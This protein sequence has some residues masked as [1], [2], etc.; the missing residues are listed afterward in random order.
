[1]RRVLYLTAIAPSFDTGGGGEI[2]Q[3]HLLR[4]LAERFELHLLIAGRLRDDRVRSL[5]TSVV[6]APVP[7]VSDPPGR[8][9]RRLRDLEWAL[10]ARQPDEVA[11]QRGVRKALAQHLRDRPDV[12]AVCVEYIGLAPLLPR[13]R[14][15]LWA[16]TVHNLTSEMAAHRAAIAPGTRQRLM[17]G[18]ERRNAL[19][20]EQ[21]AIQ[22]YDLV[23]AV[24]G[25]DAERLGGG[26]A[27]VPNGVDVERIR[28]SPLPETTAVVFTGALHTQPN[29]DGITWFCREVWP[30]VRERVADASLKIVGAS[31]PEEVLALASL[32]GVS[33]HSDVPD[34]VPFLERAQVAV[35]PLRVGSGSR[36]KALEAMAAG[37]P[38]VTTTIGI[39]GLEIEPSVHALVADKADQFAGSVVRC[40]T[41]SNLAGA[42]AAHGRE[43]VEAQYAWDRIGAAYARLLADKID[44]AGLTRGPPVLANR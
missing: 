10:I 29:Q 1:M 39:G 36:L 37:R 40:L 14:S 18:L 11:R 6:E 12:D 34:V 13:E 41:D 42:L 28:P 21:W 8:T 32:G 38:V 9:R 26:A 2:R 25:V 27:V 15:E 17:L 35:I 19:R 5:L 4:A 33:V 30:L 7:A 43:L 20:L 44:Q 24:S 22:A 31:P 3:A 23:V 16:L